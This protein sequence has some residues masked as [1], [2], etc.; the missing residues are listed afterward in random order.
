MLPSTRY[1]SIRL[2]LNTLRYSGNSY[3]GATLLR[4]RSAESAVSA[5]TLSGFRN[6]TGLGAEAAVSCDEGE[7]WVH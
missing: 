3:S 5:L 1:P 2:P 7:N 6:L 4:E